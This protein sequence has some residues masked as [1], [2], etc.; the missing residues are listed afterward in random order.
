MTKKSTDP[1]AQL[2]DAWERE[3]RRVENESRS[4]LTVD[5]K[6]AEMHARVLRECAR[7][8]REVSAGRPMPERN[9]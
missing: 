5:R 6:L 1:T 3:A 4:M 9:L 2:P 7:D 8:H